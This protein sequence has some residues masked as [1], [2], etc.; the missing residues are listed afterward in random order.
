MSGE[1]VDLSSKADVTPSILKQLI[2]DA[3]DQDTHIESAES[4]LLERT[5]A[6]TV[7]P[8]QVV[9]LAVLL[10]SA[11]TTSFIERGVFNLTE[12]LRDSTKL[13]REVGF[14]ALYHLALGHYKLGDPRTALGEVSRLLEMKS[15]HTSALAL[16]QLS[17]DRMIAKQKNSGLFSRLFS[18]KDLSSSS[19]TPSPPLPIMS[20]EEEELKRQ[21]DE[22]KRQALASM[23]A[24]AE[25]PEIDEDALIREIIAEDN[26]RH[27]DSTSP[28]VILDENSG[29][30]A[31]NRASFV[32]TATSSSPYGQQRDSYQSDF[33]GA[34]ATAP[35][36]K[37]TSV[38]SIRM[39][40]QRAS[41]WVRSKRATQD[42]SGLADMRNTKPHDS[43]P[44]GLLKKRTRPL[45]A[46][47]SARSAPSAEYLAN[48]TGPSTPNQGKEDGTMEDPDD[49]SEDEEEDD[50]EPFQPPQFSFEPY[51]PSP[52]IGRLE[53]QLKSLPGPHAEQEEQL[54]LR[55]QADIARCQTEYQ[56]L[57]QRHQA[58]QYELLRRQQEEVSALQT[59]Q[60]ALMEEEKCMMALPLAEQSMD[61][62]L[63]LQQKMMDVTGR[64]S[65]LLLAQQ[66]SQ[67]KIVA[68]QQGEQ[69]QRQEAFK[70]LLAGNN[71][72]IFD[73][74]ATQANELLDVQGQI[75]QLKQFD[76]DSYE[77]RRSMAGDEYRAHVNELMAQWQAAK[78]AKYA[79]RLAKRQEREKERA[80]KAEEARTP[81]RER[82]RERRKKTKRDTPA[83][84]TVMMLPV[85]AAV[86]VRVPLRCGGLLAGQLQ[87]RGA[88]SDRILDHYKN[89]RNVGT[90]DKNS[91]EV[92]TGLVGAPACGDV[93]KL[94]IQVDPTSRRVSDAK[95]KTF[96]C[97]SA[98]ASSSVATE[99][100]R[101]KTIEEILEIK[102]Q[103]IARY[104]S[105]PPV[106]LHCSMLAEDAIKAAA[107]DWKMKHAEGTA[108]ATPEQ[109]QPQQ[110]TAASAQGS[111]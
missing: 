83:S 42:L 91:Q 86:R 77:M 92:G 84:T 50:I 80:R 5:K 40:H 108:E 38:V 7:T 27:F 31:N 63:L 47:Q 36:M 55:Q 111:G 74:R 73:L 12:L 72:Q 88:Y 93:L 109:P 21:E 35:S 110:G 49:E 15:F 9:N 65:P 13:E 34:G 82:E 97:G 105:L 29:F 104:L 79:E 30:G 68:D 22:R 19:L 70:V 43:L 81:V 95:F 1:F 100:V 14:C 23:F 41:M 37:I 18:K 6:G 28:R 46:S 4:E 33:N 20:P 69:K 90:L 61:A 58:A 71:Q 78:D 32:S 45:R 53:A 107:Y 62:M 54:K 2:D 17:I 96:G 103:D 16:K 39:P 101:G 3:Q 85:L 99:W 66:Q 51:V 75:S 94:Q 44:I 56:E 57:L 11:K 64:Q 25:G 60:M 59:E 8:I 10:V 98:I 67:V 24:S 87:R 48:L 26:Q 102:N 106:K 89:P 76:Y 52:D